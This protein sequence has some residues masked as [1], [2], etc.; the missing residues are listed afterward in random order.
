[1]ANKQT[2]IC[3]TVSQYLSKDLIKEADEKV[4]RREEKE[5]A[6][7]RRR[8][9]KRREARRKD[10]KKKEARRMQDKKRGSS[11][12]LDLAQAEMERIRKR[13]EIERNGETNNKKMSSQEI[14]EEMIKELQNSKLK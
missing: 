9:A 11:L 3:G 4:R 14:R 8:E 13:K 10:E 12:K 5:K 2:L 1:M 7:M 6:D